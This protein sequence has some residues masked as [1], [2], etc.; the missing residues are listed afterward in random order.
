[1]SKICFVADGTEETGTKIIETLKSLGGVNEDFLEGIG[2]GDFYFV[3]CYGVITAST[4]IPTDYTLEDVF[5]SLK[6]ANTYPR[7]MIVSNT[8]IDISKSDSREY[9]VVFGFNE[10]LRYP[11]LAYNCESLEE[12]KEKSG[13]L[14]NFNWSYA[15]ELPSVEDKKIETLAKIEKLK[16]EI[17]ELE[18]SI[19]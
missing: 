8:P 6:D 11:W 7:V 12:M 3:N 18:D 15:V 1:M 14:T 2:K 16:A 10:R 17:K 4:L 5:I 19:H 13:E 9:R